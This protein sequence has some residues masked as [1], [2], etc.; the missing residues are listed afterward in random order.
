MSYEEAKKIQSFVYWINGR[1]SLTTYV[2]AVEPV[3]VG[4]ERFQ[5]YIYSNEDNHVEL[6]DL[7]LFGRGLT[8]LWHGLNCMIDQYNAG[9][10]ITRYVKALR[11]W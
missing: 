2:C 6:N 4:E 9:T 3:F 8:E 5:V 1:N 7:F 10:T 11:I